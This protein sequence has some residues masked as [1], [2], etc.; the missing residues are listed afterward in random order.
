[1]QVKRFGVFVLLVVVLFSSAV[2]AGL[3]GRLL[4]KREGRGKEA[5]LPASVQQVKDIAYGNHENQKIDVYY[6]KGQQNLPVLFMVHGGGWRRGD[7]GGAHV[8]GNKAAHWVPKGFVFVSANYRMVPDADPVVQADDVR[9]ALA[10]AQAHAQE[11]GGDPD[12][13]IIM[14]H[15]AGAHLIAMVTALYAESLQAGV[16]PW[17]GSIY[18]DSGALDAE[19][20]MNNRHPR[21][22]DKAFGDDPALWR[23]ASPTLIMQG[24]TVPVLIVCSSRRKVACEQAN[25]YAANAHALGNVVEVQPEDMGHGPILGDLAKDNEYTT[26]VERFMGKLD[27]GVS[28]RLR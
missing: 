20:I 22:Y 14:G 26:R 27:A 4:G 9:A 18:L 28:Q 13:F 16:R 17:L 5:D 23:A 2:E 6:Q 11:W 24:R 10:F 21:L 15:S 3:L 8:A 12:K 7:K 25:D 19:K 1:M